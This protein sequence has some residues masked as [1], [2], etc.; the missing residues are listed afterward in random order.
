MALARVVR[1]VVRSFKWP[2]RAAAVTWVRAGGH[3]VVWLAPRKARLLFAAP[4]PDDELDLG[5][6]SAL[7]LG[8]SEFEIRAAAPLPASRSCQSRTTATASCATASCAIP[9]TRSRP[10]PSRWTASRAHPVAATTGSSSETP[11]SPASKRPAGP[12]SRVAPTR[13]ATTERWSWCCSE[14]NAANTWRRTTV[15]PFTP[16]APTRAVRFRPEA[17]AAY[18]R[19]RRS[20]AWWTAPADEGLSRAVAVIG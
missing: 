13:G 15:A 10:A 6:W 17:S 12:T 19:A 11:M 7:D 5:R 2:F 18:R 1:P 16:F 20:W 4:R 9:S 8:R 14:T 3:A